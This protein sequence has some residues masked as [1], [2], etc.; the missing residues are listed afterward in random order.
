MKPT[1]VKELNNLLKILH[2]NG[3]ETYQNGEFKLFIKLKDK[4]KRKAKEQE[5]PQQD[6]TVYD[7]TQQ[8]SQEDT[9]FWST[10]E[11]S[12]ALNGQ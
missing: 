3:V 12:E 6:D 7:Q 9:L 2:K 5:Q 4:P 8:W 1:N 11:V 10:G